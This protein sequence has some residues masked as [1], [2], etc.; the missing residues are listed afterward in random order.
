VVIAR[1]K[2]IVFGKVVDHATEVK[3]PV[4]PL[5][6][7]GIL[8]ITPGIFSSLERDV[9]QSQVTNC[10]IEQQHFIDIASISVFILG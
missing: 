1:G 4:Q 7:R 6:K 3:K 5:Q 9:H 8:H 2:A 10:F